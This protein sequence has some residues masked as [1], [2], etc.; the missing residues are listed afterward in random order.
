[1]TAPRQP[2]GPVGAEAG[3]GLTG[4]P[5][6]GAFLARL[7]RL[8]PAT[9]VRLRSVAG[10]ETT[11]PEDSG[12]EPIARE[13]TGPESAGP[14]DAG[15]TALWARL[16]WGVLVCRTVAGAGP[17]DATVAAAEL[18]AE[19]GRAGKRLPGRRDAQWRWPLPSSTGRLVETV[20]GAD[21]R[22]IA[23]AAAGTLRTA[24]T[25][26]VAG[27]AVGQR[28]LRDALL[29]HVAMVVTDQPAGA[30]RIEVSQRLVQ[31]VV[32]MGFLG[33]AETATDDRVHVRLAGRWVGLSAPF[34]AAWSLK[35]SE[36]RLTPVGDRPNV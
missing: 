35:V 14:E 9:L 15:R 3:H 18:L 22:R 1:M 32:R 8:D 23:A 13:A 28:V 5:D 7:T 20:A 24:A 33:P 16:P 10:P 30:A 34:G 19:L 6:A 25:E 26:G 12:Q 4:V 27:R 21:L 36:M 29:D 17:G 31:A 11:G 2:G